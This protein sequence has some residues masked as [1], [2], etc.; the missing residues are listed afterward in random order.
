MKES[1]ETITVNDNALTC[2]FSLPWDRFWARWIDLLIH[3]LITFTIFYFLVYDP[4]ENVGHLNSPILLNK[5]LI[6]LLIGFISFV[7]YETFFLCVFAATPGKALFRIQV[8]DCAGMKLKV[9]QALKRA[10]S[11]YC[12]GLFFYILPTIGPPIG[13]WLS[14]YYYTKTG[15][16]R[17][18]KTSGSVVSQKEI[19]TAC[20]RQFIILSSVCIVVR[21]LPEIV[22]MVCIFID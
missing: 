12:L 21:H 13:F 5:I 8:L 6:V 22:F 17:W 10:F 19:S 4:S 7:F 3:V 20:R 9:L 11:F 1:I 14:S 16:F 2:S 15:K 18:D